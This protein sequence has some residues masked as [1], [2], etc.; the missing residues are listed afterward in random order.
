MSYPPSSAALAGVLQTFPS[1]TRMPTNSVDCRIY[2]E[3]LC[4]AAND[5][6]RIVERSEFAS[7]AFAFPNH[8]LR[9]LF[10]ACERRI[11]TDMLT[12]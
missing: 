9:V 7:D 3:T 4:E 10:P 2:L 6:N 8:E 11:V 5:W 12:S 1:Y